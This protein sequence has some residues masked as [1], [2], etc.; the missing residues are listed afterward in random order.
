M[1]GGQCDANALYGFLFVVCMGIVAVVGMPNN[2]NFVFSFFLS[3]L[4]VAIIC[5][6]LSIAIL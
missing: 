2:L 4:C 5:I 6:T 3:L 1:T